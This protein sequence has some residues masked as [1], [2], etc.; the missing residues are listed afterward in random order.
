MVVLQTKISVLRVVHGYLT[1]FPKK[2]DHRFLIGFQVRLYYR[3]F[4]DLVNG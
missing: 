4:L 3:N 2:L 1:V